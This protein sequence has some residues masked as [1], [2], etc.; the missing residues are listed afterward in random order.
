[1]VCY[2]LHAYCISITIVTILLIPPGFVHIY[3]FDPFLYILLPLYHR[4]LRGLQSLQTAHFYLLRM[5]DLLT[6]LHTS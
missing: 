1:M 2:F 5:D 4:L 6:D 3:P